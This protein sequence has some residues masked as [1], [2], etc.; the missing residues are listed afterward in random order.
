MINIRNL[1]LEELNDILIKAGYQRF[2]AKQIFNWLKLGRVA[3]FDLMTNLPADLR[4]YLKQ[5]FVLNSV[6][7]ERLLK[8][9]CGSATKMLCRLLDGNLIEAVIMKYKYGFSVCVSTQVGCRMGCAF[10]VSGMHGFVRNLDAAEILEQ[11][12]LAREF[13][14]ERIG[15][16][17]LM[18][19]GEPL[20]NFDNV[21]RFVELISSTEGLNIGQRNLSLSTSGVVDKIYQLM[22]LKMQI[23]LSISL[24]ATNDS[25]RNRLMPIN[26]R[27]NLSQLLEA[28]KEYFRATRRRISFEYIMLNQV[29]DS[30][31]FAEE[32]KRL[33]C[34]F[35]AHVNLIPANCGRG[36]FKSSDPKVIKA[37]Q[38][39]LEDLGLNVTVRRKLG[40]DVNAACGQMR[41]S[42]VK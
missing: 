26:R 35:A 28:C 42:C 20:D 8:S 34:G 41:S 19:V 21:V 33:L 11:V 23:T 10:C 2:R 3:D 31:V 36:D 30:M 17:V 22:D 1:K 37:F 24:H 39:R 32:L 18:G 27:W 29:N 16:V 9:S 14:G 15:H 40:D 38:K 5:T 13:A 25:L 7:L 12:L 6:K 4:K